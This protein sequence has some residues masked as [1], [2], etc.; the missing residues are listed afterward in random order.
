MIAFGKRFCSR[1]E[2]CEAGCGALDHKVSE[3]KE[4]FGQQAASRESQ[5]QG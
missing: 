4:A 5:R 3:T 2:R 1:S